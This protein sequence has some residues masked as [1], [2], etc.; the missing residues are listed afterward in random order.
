MQELPGE[1]KKSIGPMILAEAAIWTP[2]QFLNFRLLPAQ[3]Q[4]M[5]VNLMSI[6][7]AAVLSWCATGRS[8]CLPV[9]FA[10]QCG[11]PATSACMQGLKSHS[12]A[13]MWAHRMRVPARHCCAFGHLLSPTSAVFG[14]PQTML[15]VDIESYS[16]SLEPLEFLQA[17]RAGHE[18][19]SQ[20]TR[21]CK[22]A[23]LPAC[24]LAGHLKG[25]TCCHGSSSG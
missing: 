13:N 12:C 6:V 8:Q 1:L 9:H 4:Q 7:E 3:H 11:A 2:V 20:R 14:M 21:R 10:A 16:V 19:L 23:A 18:P 15:S 17:G 22:P 24:S 5:F 25:V